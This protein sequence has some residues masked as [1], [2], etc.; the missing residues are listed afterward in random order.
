VLTGCFLDI[1]TRPSF[2]PS[3]SQPSQMGNFKHQSFRNSERDREDGQDRLRNV[4]ISG[5]ARIQLPTSCSFLKNTT[6]IVSTWLTI[7][8]PRSE[9]RFLIYRLVIAD[10]LS[11]LLHLTLAQATKEKVGKKEEA[12]PVKTGDVVS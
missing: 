4:S 7:Y 10:S 6:V 1:P 2:R 5:P 9:T 12:S 8:V 11:R 3:A